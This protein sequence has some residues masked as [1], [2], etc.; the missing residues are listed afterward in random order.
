M[1]NLQVTIKQRETTHTRF[2]ELVT[3]IIPI[4]SAPSDAVVEK[5]FIPNSLRKL[6]PVAPSKLMNDDP[7]MWEAMMEANKSHT[8]YQI[9]MAVYAETVSQLEITLCQK[10]IRSKFY[11]LVSTLALANIMTKKTMP[12]AL[13]LTCN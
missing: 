12:E 2:T 9:T 8:A 5:L 10:H 3:D 11:N 7:T 13:R 4:S 1:L 6:N